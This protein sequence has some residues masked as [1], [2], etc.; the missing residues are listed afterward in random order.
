[1][2][3]Q[4][5]VQEGSATTSVIQFQQMNDRSKQK[6]QEDG[7]KQQ[8]GSEYNNQQIHT[9]KSQIQQLWEWSSKKQQSATRGK[10]AAVKGEQKA[11][12]AISR[13][14]RSNITVDGYGIESEAATSDNQFN[15]E[16][17]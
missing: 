6:Q 9:A 14:R 4:H 10:T 1:M 13:H 11:K 16:L 3:K 7:R 2:E 15:L 5:S 17:N 12:T 8:G